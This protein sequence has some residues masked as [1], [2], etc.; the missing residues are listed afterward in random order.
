[1]K[2]LGIFCHNAR[3]QGNPTGDEIPATSGYSS[4]V[5]PVR[6]VF[7]EMGSFCAWNSSRASTGSGRC[8]C[9][10]AWF[11]SLALYLRDT[12][13]KNPKITLRTSFLGFILDWFLGHWQPAEF[14]Y[15]CVKVGWLTPENHVQVRNQ[16]EIQVLSFP[17]IAI[18]RFEIVLM[19]KFKAKHKVQRQER[20][21]PMSTKI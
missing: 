3:A 11:S 1:M 20:Y 4:W 7:K 8:C 9:S 10:W 12:Y 6:A 16:C 18:L 21:K 14:F 17:L 13:T 15:V 5:H 2:S 19:L